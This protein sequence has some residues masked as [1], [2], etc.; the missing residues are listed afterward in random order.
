MLF[1]LLMNVK[2]PTI[3]G[4][5]TFMSRKILC[6]AELSMKFFITSG[7]GIMVHSD[8]MILHVTFRNKIPEV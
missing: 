4:I 7:L 1:F 6:S 2:M 8:T 5:L 3:V